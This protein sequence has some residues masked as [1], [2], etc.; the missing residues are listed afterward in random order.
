MKISIKGNELDV[1][2]AEDEATR[3]RGLMNK[4]FLSPDS[5]MLFRW[6]NATP[7]SFWMKDTSI[8]LDIAFI[9]S[10][11]KIINIEQLTPFS[12]KSILSAGPASC[13]LE[14]NSG[15]FKKHNI[16]A[17]DIV[18]GVF[19]FQKVEHEPERHPNGK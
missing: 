4:D 12:L 2:L 13:A 1:S 11:G 16:E 9:A 5:G 18:D 14:V 3:T 15:W 19:N 7:R 17:G 8:P 6:P 10:D